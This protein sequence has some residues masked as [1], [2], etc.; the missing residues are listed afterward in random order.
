MKLKIELIKV[1]DRIRQQL[2]DLTSLKESI[3]KVGLLH[4]IIV[5]ED[6]E[7]VSGYRRLEACRQLGWTEIEA[8]IID[9]LADDVKEL[10]IEYHE[11]LGRIDLTI[12]EMQKYIDEKER[13]LHPPKSENAIWAWLK[14]LW[15]KIK[16]LFRD[17]KQQNKLE[18]DSMLS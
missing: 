9:T 6:Y 15:Q 5:N 3:E 8:T 13:L 7:L 12:S 2:G 1:S 16:N 11:N 17:S 4:S 10:D 14:K 18:E